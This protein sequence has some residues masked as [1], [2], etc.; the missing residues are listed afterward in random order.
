MNNNQE[1][2]LSYQDLANKIEREGKRTRLVVVCST[3]CIIAT[4]ILPH[5]ALL[6][7]VLFLILFLFCLGVESFVNQ[8]R[9]KRM[10]SLY[11]ENQNRA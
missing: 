8:K 11:S 6:L 10:K 2:A 9:K 3:I 4:L 5:L 7:L 1:P